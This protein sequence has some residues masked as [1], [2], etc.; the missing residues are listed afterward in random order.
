MVYID[1]LLAAD[2]MSDCNHAYTPMIESF[3][4]APALDNYVLNPKKISAYQRFTGSIQWLA[5]Q[6]RPD[7]LQ[8]V[9]KLSQHNIKPTDQCWTAVT[10]L[11]QYLKR[12]QTYRNWYCNGNLVSYRYSDS[13][14]VDNLYNWRLIARYVFILN[15]VPIT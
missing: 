15:S 4:V 10:C 5:F 8:I 14:L 12:T 3:C 9:A 2:Q 13:S 6:T 7:I 11:L 1:Q